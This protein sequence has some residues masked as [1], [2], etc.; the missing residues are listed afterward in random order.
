MAKLNY[1]LYVSEYIGDFIEGN[2]NLTVKN[3]GKSGTWV[4]E[5]TDA[6]IE[7][8]GTNLEDATEGDRFASG[9]I[10]G[11]KIYNG[12]DQLMLDVSSLKVNAAKL[13]SVFLDGGDFGLQDALNF[14]TAGN[15]TVIGTKNS[16]YLYSGAG[17]DTLTG[18]GGSDTFVF[19]AYEMSEVEKKKGEIDTITDFG[20]K[21]KEKDYLEIEQD[22]TTQKINKNHDVQLNFEDGSALILEGVTKKQFAAYWDSFEQ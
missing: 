9:K 18:K 8:T 16:D 5:D 3:N 17:N 21:G 13:S 2:F 19:Q 20:L 14:I 22:F 15:D 7:V 1:K 12:M 6:R 11:L 4:N 10:T